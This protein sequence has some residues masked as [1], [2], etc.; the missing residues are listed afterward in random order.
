MR[1]FISADMEGVTGVTHPQDVIPGRAQYERFR[2]FLTADVN[3]AIEGASQGGATEFL[4]NEAHN[5]MRNVFLE[6][7]DERAHL[8]VGSRKPLSMMQGF[9]GADLAFFVG[10]HARAGAEGILS[11]TF[12]SPSV[13]TDVHLN[14]EPCSEAR[15]NATLAGLSGIPVGLVT[16]DDLTCAEA[17]SLYANV[18][19]AQVKTAIDRYTARCLPQGA[20]LER[21]RAAAEDAVRGSGDLIPY[22]PEPPYT[23]TVEFATASTPA[24]V[25]FF[26]QLERVDDRRVSWTHDDYTTA[27]KM[28]IGVMRMATSDPDYG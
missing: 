16:G 9:E 24:G 10:Y 18:K 22:A 28:F 12:N 11:H 4:V 26:P 14:G 19:T 2:R 3:A 25:M 15:M 13:V 20:A 1:V 17:E 8:I 7:L 6:D 23:F 21:I 27:F 5:G